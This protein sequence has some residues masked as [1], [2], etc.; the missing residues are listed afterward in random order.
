MAQGELRQQISG[1]SRRRQIV[2]TP[3]CYFCILDQWIEPITA[4][5]PSWLQEKSD[6]VQEV[7]DVRLR[8]STS[9]IVELSKFIE[10]LFKDGSFP[11]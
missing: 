11:T 8:N 3:L 4:H 1:I 9:S 10:L 2:K 5:E 6:P 7:C